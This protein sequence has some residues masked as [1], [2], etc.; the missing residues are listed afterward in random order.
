[1]ESSLHQGYFE[2][3]EIWGGGIDKCLGGCKHVQ[4]ANLHTKTLKNRKNCTELGGGVSS[5]KWRGLYPPPL[6]HTG[7]EDCILAVGAQLCGLFHPTD[8]TPSYC[9]RVLVIL[10]N[11]A[12]WLTVHTVIFC[13]YMRRTSHS[14][15][16]RLV[17][18]HGALQTRA[19]L[20][21]KSSSISKEDL[22]HKP[23]RKN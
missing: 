9:R 23:N 18:F 19:E 20:G 1:L 17:S 13:E 12:N 10:T 22:Y 21:C 14:W 16:S 7:L 8:V 6:V 3:F 4:T 5:L 2:E 15:D 11:N